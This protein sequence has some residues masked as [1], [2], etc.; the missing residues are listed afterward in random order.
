MDFTKTKLTKTFIILFCTLFI[1]GGVSTTIN[2][3]GVPFVKA[4]VVRGNQHIDTSLIQKAITKTTLDSRY[5]EENIKDDLDA[6]YALGYFAS[7]KA[8]PSMVDGGVM[9]AFEVVENPVVTDVIFT[10]ANKVPLVN[11]IPQMKLRRGDVLNVNDLFEDIDNLPDWVLDNHGVSLRPVNLNVDDH[12]VVEILVAESIIQDVLLDGNTKT[13]DHV[14]MREL[15]FGPGDVVDLNQINRSLR[16]VLML[17]FFDEISFS[18]TEGDTPDKTVLTIHVTE[19]KT[20]NADFGIGYSSRDG[21]FG[22]TDI[23]EENFLGRAQRINAYYELGKGHR[24]FKLGFYEP[25]IDKSGLSFGANVYNTY[26][27]K[28]HKLKI[29]TE[30][31]DVTGKL[32]TTGGDITIGRRFGEYS[33][34]NLT[35]R[36][37]KNEYSGDIAEHEDDYRS[38]TFGFGAN[39]NTTDHPFYPT[40]GFVNNARLEIGTRLF[41]AEAYSKFELEHSRYY[42]IDKDSKFVLAVRGKGGRLLQGSLRN[43]ELF[44]LGGSETLRGYNYGAEGLVGDKMLLFNAE[45]RFPI[46]EKVYG[47]A[48]TDMGKAWESGHE[49]NLMEVLNNYSYGAG[50]RVD[51]PLGL[52]RFDYGIGRDD[53]NI[54]KGQFYFGIGQTF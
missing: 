8:L 12:G 6:I 4:I 44:R 18:A 42:G 46:F 16:N 19:R 52:L 7:T 51:T 32:H 35:V 30:V 53:D 38:L 26:S 23:S 45:F 5:S 29:G 43:E 39:T 24:S 1:V 49:M 20:G 9:I 50:L 28:K 3:Q 11:Y 47:V 15:S 21:I 36:L 34:G 48:F 40:E 22:Y 25:Y 14:I 17:G 54:R 37:N 2:A 41:G 10:G 27:D 31:E 13:K 33:R